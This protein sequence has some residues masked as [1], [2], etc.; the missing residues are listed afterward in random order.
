[1]TVRDGKGGKD[2]RILLACRAVEHLRRQL[3]E[4]AAASCSG[5]DIPERPARSCHWAEGRHHLDRRLIQKALRRAVPAAGINKPGTCH[6]LRHSFA[7]HLLG[8]SDVKTTM[9][10]TLC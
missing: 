1:M 4:C 9:I 7:T 10:Y 3:G 2:R 5:S 8:H 6:S